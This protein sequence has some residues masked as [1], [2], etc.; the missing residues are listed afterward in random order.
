ML[1][2]KMLREGITPLSDFQRA[3]EEFQLKKQKAIQDAQGNDPATIKIANEIDKALREGNIE[4][5]NLLHQVHKTMD[6]G[7]LP[8]T[9][10]QPMG[11]SDMGNMGGN[12]MAMGGSSLPPAFDGMSTGDPLQESLNAIQ[13]QQ[14]VTGVSPAQRADLVGGGVGLMPGYAETMAAKEATIEKSKAAA[15]KV[16]EAQGV[17]SSEI[18]ERQSS[19]PQLLDT[20]R[21]L[22]DL[23]KTAT[24]TLGGRAL[25]WG[26]RE[27][28]MDVPESAIA[29]TEYISMVDNEVLPLLRQTFGAQ[30]TQKE[31]ESLKVTLGDPNKSPA[32]KDAVLRSFIR[33]KMENI[34]STARQVGQA[35]PYSQEYISNVVNSIG[36]K[37]SGGSGGSVKE[38]TTATNPHTGQ[39]IIFKGGQWR[40]M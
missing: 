39:K 1:D 9:G 10:S 3:E 19:M 18:L 25:D 29:R 14:Q 6:K 5:A 34:N 31:G 24:Y 21:R 35:Q 33:T 30:F 32:E 40:P 17:A 28:G 23:G 27:V 37:K 16:G 12:G 8:Y 11:V 26:M 2:Y 7:I 13:Q 4:R 36:N 20:V 22:S 15:K 38:G